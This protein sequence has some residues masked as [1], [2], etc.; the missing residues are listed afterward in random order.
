MSKLIGITAGKQEHLNKLNNAYID[1]FTQ[2]GIVPII[3]PVYKI[4]SSEVISDS[5]RDRIDKI[6]TNIESKLDALVL[7]GGS[8]INPTSYSST[9]VNSIHCNYERDMIE[10]SLMR[11]FIKSGKTIVGVCRGFQLLSIAFDMYLHQGEY[12]EKFDEK[13]LSQLFEFEKRD[14]PLHKVSLHGDFKEFTGIS[15]MYVNSMHHQY[16]PISGF[17][18]KSLMLLAKTDKVVEMFKHKTL[19]IVGCQYH[20]EE[21]DQGLTLQYILEKYLK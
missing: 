4:K 16:V 11:K 15:S 14:E 7:S 20:L 18:S 21:Y 6:T 9:N 19:P 1:A 10:I 13:H 2:E 12:D 8:D 5:E 3:I 17:N